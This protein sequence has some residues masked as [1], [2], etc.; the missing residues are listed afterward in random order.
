MV[1][2][3]PFH[4]ILILFFFSWAAAGCSF[5]SP[6]LLNSDS[7]PTD[8][9]S[10]ISAA[11]IG[12]SVQE[13]VA[14]LVPDAAETE[15]PDPVA[16]FVARTL[17]ALTPTGTD[18]RMSREIIT[19]VYQTVEALKPA[20]TEAVSPEWLTATAMNK[21]IA[22]Y[23]RILTSTAAPEK[24]GLSTAALPHEAT[25]PCD[26]MTFVADMSVPDGTV[27]NPGEAFR[28]TWRIKNGG[29]CAWTTAYQ[30]VFT[31]GDRIGAPEAVSLPFPVNPGE[32]VDISVDMTAPMNSGT[33]RG[34]WML[35][36]PNGRLIGLDR[37]WENGVWV[38]IRVGA[39][40]SLPLSC[41]HFRTA[42][43]AGGSGEIRFSIGV[44]NTGTTTWVK[45]AVQL[46]HLYGDLDNFIGKNRRYALPTDVQPGQSVE[47][48]GLNCS[49]GCAS[50]FYD[51][52]SSDTWAI[53]SNSDTICTFNGLGN[54]VELSP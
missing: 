48:I 4:L 23:D 40:G 21:T 6:N 43:L 2:R 37:S 5:G 24:Q 50:Y 52:Q 41:K 22:A 14:A 20:A 9:L 27:L 38:D 36:N 47:F 39:G 42:F 53:V 31:K 17:T 11:L 7:N 34:H 45:S 19:A 10:T 25:P 49:S 35:K 44:Q 33:Y 1:K 32:S 29:T 30:F 51:S 54:R 26:V 8:A 12:T 15:P 46:V 16:T 28:K 13:T 18:K 3:A